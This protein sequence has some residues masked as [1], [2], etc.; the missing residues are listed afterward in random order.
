MP[1]AYL[2]TMAAAGHEVHLVATIR[3]RENP[4][5]VDGVQV[6]PL[7]YWWRAKRA[8]RPE[9]IVTVAGDRQAERLM[10]NLRRVPRLVLPHADADFGEFE[11][12]CIRQLPAHQRAQARVTVPDD[13]LAGERIK[14]V[15]WIHYGVPYRRA[16]S[17][18]M[19]QT[20]MRGLRDAGMGVLVVCSS[21]PEAPPS[22]EVDG[23]PYLHLGPRAAEL[24]FRS[25]RPQVMVTH[26]NYAARATGLAREIGA[27]SVLLMH[28][29]HDY[30]A[31]SMQ[32]GPDMIVYNTEWV[33]ASLAARYLEVDRT[34]SQIVHPPVVPDEHRAEAAG[35]RVTLV[36]LSSDKGVYTWRA[37]ARALP[38][39]PFLGV[40]GAHGIQITAP[41][42]PNMRVIPQ[43]SDMRADVWAQTRVLLVPSVYESYGM[44]GVEA[45]ASGIPV[46]AHPTPGLRE[47]LG[48]G[49]TFIDRDDV[50]S[51]AAAISEL[52]P[53]GDR[54][55]EATRAALAR[56]AFLADRMSVELKQW[57]EGV[58]QLSDGCDRQ[59]LAGRSAV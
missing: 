46:I 16:G 37:A 57:V 20:M 41:L 48:D 42:A 26:H 7:G 12:A 2:R 19:L 54:R 44:A 15:A 32:A 17:E 22:W 8:A 43:T 38:N 39:L 30:S 23:V 3:R 4:R 6:W 29:D 24:L 5:T 27:R 1:P 50:R 25:M 47:A 34:P 59:L 52:Y 9:V 28:S 31:R 11:E 10:P 35:D 21:M 13:P 58:R 49:A 51:W 53:D 33:R 36:N 55:A 45:L 18:T 14:V 40:T 56:S